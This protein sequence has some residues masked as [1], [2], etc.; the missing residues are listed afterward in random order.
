MERNYYEVLEVAASA[1]ADEIKKAYRRLSKQYHPDAATG[2]KAEAENRFKEI[3]SAYGV[4]SDPEKRAQYD[5]RLNGGGGGF[6][7]EDL[8]SN[9]GG[10][11]LAAFREQFRRRPAAENYN[12]DVKADF[13][14]E[15]SFFGVKRTLNY[16]KKSE[17]LSCS[18][19]GSQFGNSLTFCSLCGGSGSRMINVGGNM[20]TSATCSDCRGTGKKIT[21]EC[22]DCSGQGHSIVEDSVEVEVPKG[23]ANG[24]YI[25][26]PKKGHVAGRNTGNLNVHFME[27]PHANFIRQGADLVYRKNLSPID[28]MMGGDFV[29]PVIDGEIKIKVQE[30]TKPSTLLRVKGK[31]MPVV[32]TSNYGNLVVSLEVQMPTSL[33]EEEREV[34]KQFQELSKKEK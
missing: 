1:T 2:D 14:L 3:A 18:G 21:S 25:V 26:F 5:A 24:N 11:P 4:L 6:S 27:I 23:I 7:I 8:F 13:T 10:D 32:N 22:P 34:L 15:D 17:C 9:F 12:L 19:N 30:C 16:K 33:T 20:Y 29:V 28:F 31:G